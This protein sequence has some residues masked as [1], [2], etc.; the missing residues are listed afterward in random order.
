M[1]TPAA[2]APILTF[3]KNAPRPPLRRL[4]AMMGKIGGLDKSD[5]SELIELDFQLSQSAGGDAKKKKT[6][7]EIEKEKK[8]RETEAVKKKKKVRRGEPLTSDGCARTY[9]NKQPRALASA[10]GGTLQGG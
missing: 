8:E 5:V 1:T 6:Q 10:A 9:A 2:I 3:M 4:K 7:A